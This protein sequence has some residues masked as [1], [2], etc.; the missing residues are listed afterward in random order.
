MNQVSMNVKWEEHFISE[1]VELE[2]KMS[3]F[4]IESLSKSK[5]RL[6]LENNILS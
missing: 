1:A 5:I 2:E 6:S 4:D 3:S